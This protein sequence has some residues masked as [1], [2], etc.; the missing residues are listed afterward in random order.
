MLQNLSIGQLYKIVSY[1]FTL[2]TSTEPAI[3][4]SN[5]MRLIEDTH[6]TL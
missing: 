4:V 1:M 2:A 3:N 5:C 6:I